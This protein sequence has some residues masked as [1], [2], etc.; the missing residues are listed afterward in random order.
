M[1]AL[2]KA[3]LAEITST[4]NPTEVKDSSV[5]VQFNPTSLRVQIA[6]KTAGGQ[7]A[8]A[9]A[10]QR[11]GTG[12]MQVS[13]DLVFDT[14]DEAGEGGKAVDVLK[15]TA[16]VERFV[17]PKSSKPGEEAPPRVLFE[18][19]SF[20]VQGTME[21]ANLDLDFFD[22]GG[23]PLRA[24]V[25]VTIKG[26]DPRWTYQPQ[27]VPSSANQPSNPSGAQTGLPAGTP[28]TQGS[29]KAPDKVV[30]AMPGESLQQLAARHGLDPSAWRALADG[31]GNPLKLGLGQEVALPPG[32]GQGAATG[33]QSQGQDPARSN[34]QLPLVGAGSVPASA[35]PSARAMNGVSDSASSNA[36]G[37]TAPGDALRR[38]QAVASQGGLGPAIGQ[39]KAQVH[40]QGARLSL[41]AFG[42][43]GQPTADTDDRPWGMGVPLR[44]RIGGAVDAGP[45]VP[46]ATRMALGS[47]VPRNA[48]TSTSTASAGRSTRSTTPVSRGCGCKGRRSR[49]GR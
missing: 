33:R 27:P 24:K 41:G 7:Q 16:D 15:K 31:L 28:G 49:N 13:F 48:T 36:A 34:A 40:Q 25:A 8:G 14:A 46:V 23:T 42:L 3:R 38:G 19:G 1:T 17:R 35:G 30:Q 20:L 43:G 44:P 29:A 4:D 12:E 47:A 10:R 21:S 37:R 2:A 9:Q 22:A 6:N 11:P 18:W 32:L 39:V 5:P 45:V 26:Q